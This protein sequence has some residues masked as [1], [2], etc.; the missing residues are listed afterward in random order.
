MITPRSRINMLSL[1]LFFAVQIISSIS[2]GAVAMPREWNFMVYMANNNNLNRYGITNFRQMV[3]VGSNINVNL[4]LQ[5]DTLGKKEISRFFL[6]KNSPV[7]L[8]TQTNTQTSFSGTP[9]NL[10]DFAQWGSGNFPA[11]KTCLVLWNHGAG[12]KDPSIWGRTF[13]HWRDNLFVM[14]NKTGMIE[15]DRSEQKKAQ[16]KEEEERGIAF[17]DA[18]SAYLTNEDLKTSLDFMNTTMFGGNKIDIL[19]MDACHMAMVEVASQIKTAAKI[20]VASEEVEPGTGYNYATALTVFEHSGIDPQ[21]AATYLVGA[22]HNEY[23]STLADYTQSAVDLSCCDALEASVSNLANALIMLSTAGSA[24]EGFKMIRDIRFN[25]SQT[26]EFYDSD[27]IDFGHFCKSLIARAQAFLTADMSGL[28]APTQKQLSDSWNM[29]GLASTEC[30]T[31]LKGMIF[32]NAVGRNLPNATGLSI[33]FPITSIHSSYAKT[34]F[35]KNTTW[36]RFLERFIYMRFGGKS[37][38][39]TKSVPAKAVKKSPATV[40]KKTLSYTISIK[41]I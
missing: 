20:M 17:N 7:L 27:Y 29:V 30:L 5:M 19:A 39:L 31:V 32:A 40:A 25:R 16:L 1:L 2:A 34:E 24:Q 14:N 21:L 3:Q 11:A 4:L 9:A 26:T 37:P 23:Q 38:A 36:P 35:A 28:N 10:V 12:I 22:Y 15:L 18:A 33:Y 8:A 41:T 6:A 13:D